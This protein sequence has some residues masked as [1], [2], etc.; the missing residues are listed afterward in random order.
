MW[1][2]QRKIRFANNGGVA[3][4]NE[5]LRSGILLKTMKQLRIAQETEVVEKVLER[6]G[7]SE[8]TVSYGLMEIE[9]A[10]K[11]G[12][13]EKLM[14]AD[15]ILRESEDEQRL[16]LEKIIREV[17]EKRGEVIIVSTE[18]EAGTKLAALGNVAAL[19]RFP[20][21]QTGQ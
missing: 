21:P 2:S 17:E 9:K 18:H 6:L 11:M 15:S 7:K 10:A 16:N 8:A 20:L 4:I 1:K 3:G 19:L 14:L 5:A 13:I 12:A